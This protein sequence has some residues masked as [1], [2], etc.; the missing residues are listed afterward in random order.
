MSLPLGSET[1]TSTA[2]ARD[3]NVITEREGVGVSREI[4]DLTTTPQTLS[5][6]EGLAAV[7]ISYLDLGSAVGDWIYVVFDALSDADAATKLAT[8]EARIRIMLG[9]VSSKSIIFARTTPCYR[10]DVVSNVATETGDSVV[11]IIG[12]V[13]A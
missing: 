7:E 2:G 11:R 10:I 1:Q 8:A 13:D 9:E 4:L 3:V 12:K 5:F 6:A